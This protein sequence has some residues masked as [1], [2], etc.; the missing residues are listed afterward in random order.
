MPSTSRAAASR[1][2]KPIV[3]DVATVGSA[4]L[5]CVLITACA[6]GG[7]G[8]GGVALQPSA[9]PQPQS[10]QAPSQPASYDTG[11]A[12][13]VGSPVTASFGGTPTLATPGGPTFNSSGGSDS[14]PLI[15]S[16]LQ[17]TSKGVSAVSP[18]QGA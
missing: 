8:G 7:S 1:A 10:L 2:A 17:T 9:Q 12:G 13:T 5:A 14:F 16:S 6:S 3:R 4:V 15:V 11:I 18:N